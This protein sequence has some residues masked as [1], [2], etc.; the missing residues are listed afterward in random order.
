MSSNWPRLTQ[1]TLAVLDVLTHASDEDPV[2]GLRVC[3]EADLGPGTVYPI[4]ERLAEI[5]WIESW[6]EAEQPSG[7]PRRRYYRMTGVGRLQ[8]AEARAARA[9]RRRRWAP[10]TPKV[11]SGGAS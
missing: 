6:Q 1:P 9:A 4:L 8:L 2:Y 3:D 5:G 10:F 7:R 11:E